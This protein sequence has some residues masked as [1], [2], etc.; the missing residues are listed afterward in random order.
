MRTASQEGAEGYHRELKE[1]GR[2]LLEHVAASTSSL[3][4]AQA[5][6]A[7]GDGRERVEEI[8]H[9][10][11]S[12]PG[13]GSFDMVATMLLIC[14]WGEALPESVHA[15]VKER[16]TGG[17]FHRGTPRTTGCCIIRQHS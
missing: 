7:L 3:W 15:Q 10:Y 5:L 17:I 2:T 9:T 16:M 11:M 14:R 4:G 1:R 13:L 6:M 8:V 12:R